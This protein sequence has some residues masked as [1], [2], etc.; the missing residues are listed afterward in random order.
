M[1]QMWHDFRNRRKTNGTQEEGTHVAKCMHVNYTYT[2][3][4]LRMMFSALALVAFE[5]FLKLRPHA[6]KLLTVS[7]NLSLVV[8]PQHLHLFS[9]PARK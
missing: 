4:Y 3:A 8:D 1:S 6:T 7:R 5:G 9:L 2:H